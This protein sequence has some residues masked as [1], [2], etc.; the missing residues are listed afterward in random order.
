M[1]SDE[2]RQAK[3]LV[4][5][6]N[7][8]PVEFRWSEGGDVEAI[9]GQG[10][11]ASAL[12]EAARYG[13]TTW[14]SS[15][16]S[17]VD[18]LIAEGRCP[19]PTD[20]AVSRF[21]ATE[22]EEY[23][24]FYRVTCNGVLWFLQHSLPWPEE[25]T[26]A[27]RRHAWERGYLPVNEAFARAAVRELARGD[28]RGVMLHDYHFYSAPALIRRARPD[29]ALQHF[30]H[31][32]WPAPSEWRRLPEPMVVEVCRGLLGNDSIVF[33]TNE[34]VENFL[35]L[36]AA[37]L[38]SAEVDRPSGEVTLDGRRT[39]VWANG[40][41]VDPDALQ[42]TGSSPEFNRYRWLLRPPPGVRLIVR[43]D[44]VDPTKNLGRGFEAYRL[45]LRARP[46]L[47]EKVLF[48][49]HLVPSRADVPAYGRHQQEVLSAIEAVNREFGSHRWQPVRLV[50]E[51]NQVQAM[52]ALSLYDV[53]LVNPV[54]DGMN[55][56]AKE[57][58]TMNTRDGVLVLSRRAGAWQ[59]LSC[60]AIGIDPLDVAG[61]ARALEEALSMPPGERRE[62]SQ[63]LKKTIRA[64][65]LHAWF[66][67]LLADLDRRGAGAASTAA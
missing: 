40:I 56:V 27:D 33:Q 12:R 29:A 31:I 14:L 1:E 62:R 2:M 17:P 61:T 10:G 48:L 3:R 24:L 55:L 19:V 23:G 9:P 64:H 18:R 63:R 25:Q 35:D 6:S 32:P 67:A 51:H 52:A 34:C 65:D 41:S 47:R 22:E 38:Q 37:A 57:G 21:V 42:E 46:D 44:R 11:L 30:I 28:V 13:P 43:V 58:P 50:M 53:L 20:H 16:L 36:C 5:I 60:G 49:A 7:R 54:A 26:E 8:G 15:P 39:R 45:L 59:E 66:A 4:L